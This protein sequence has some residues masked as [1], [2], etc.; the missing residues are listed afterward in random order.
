M[1]LNEFIAEYFDQNPLSSITI[2]TSSNS[3]S[4]RETFWFNSVHEFKQR[5]NF[6]LQPCGDFSL[7]NSL[8][9]AF[10]LLK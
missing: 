6:D 3:I 1:L 9:Q 5:M 2:L 10:L 7:L 8:E 4:N